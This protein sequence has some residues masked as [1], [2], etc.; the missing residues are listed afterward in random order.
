MIYKF[1]TKKFEMPKRAFVFA[2][3]ALLAL[4]AAVSAPAQTVTIVANFSNTNATQYPAGTPAQ[5][6]DGKLYGTAFGATYGAFFNASTAGAISQIYALDGTSVLNPYTGM[7]LSTD[8]TFYGVSPTTVQSGSS[9][10]LF[11][12]SPGGAFTV[13]QQFAL[14]SDSEGPVAQ[15]TL[16]SNNII[17]GT[18]FTTVYEYPPSRIFTTI[19][20]FS[21]GQI[22]GLTDSLVQ[23]TNGHLYGTGNGGGSKNCGGVYEI[24]L[25]GTLLNNFSFSC[26]TTGYAGGP[27]TLAND[28]NYYG[29]TPTGGIYNQGTLFRFSPKGAVTVVHNFQG[30]PSD[31][32]GFVLGSLTLGTDGY[33]YGVTQQGGANGTGL[34]FQA[35]TAGAYKVLY[36][37]PASSQ[38]PWELVQHTNGKF[39]GF[40]VLGGSLGYGDMF[41][42]DMGLGPF[43]AFVNPFGRPTQG[44]PATSFKVASDTYMTAVVP[45]GATT[46]KVVVTTPGGTLTSNVNFRI[47]N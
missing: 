9:G 3:V 23:G 35:S 26:T 39:Y 43:V 44:I 36:S 46:G 28:G 6:R 4:T 22:T 5:G 14:G 31:G 37:F 25:A 38:Q 7:T 24:T 15:P 40:D 20:D 42:L 18:A 11:R 16:A 30:G 2:L 41:S 12:V 10:A 32:V 33:L 34:I 29:M 47:T 21:N 13:L 17:Y 27:L 19:D 1:A 8:G 45:T